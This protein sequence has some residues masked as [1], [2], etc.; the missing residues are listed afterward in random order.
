MDPVKT[1]DIRTEQNV[2]TEQVCRWGEDIQ[3]IIK[4]ISFVK[5]KN[6]VKQYHHE[7]IDKKMIRSLKKLDTSYN[8]AYLNVMN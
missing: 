2:K 8:P 4:T 6:K 7:D 3:R 5:Q 1:E